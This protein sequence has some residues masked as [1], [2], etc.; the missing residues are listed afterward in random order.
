V[1]PPIV[2]LAHFFC[3]FL[4]PSSL[5]LSG[6]RTRL[7]SCCAAAPVCMC[8]CECVCV[9][10]FDLRYVPG[11]AIKCAG[12][13]VCVHVCVCVCVCV[14]VCMCVCVCACVYVCVRACVC[15][16]VCVSKCEIDRTASVVVCDCVCKIDKTNLNMISA[17]STWC[18][19]SLKLE[20]PTLN[21]HLLPSKLQTSVPLSFE[22]RTHLHPFPTQIKHSSIKHTP[23]LSPHLKKGTPLNP[24]STKM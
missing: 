17:E 7:R 2:I 4:P 15:V 18:Q 20:P 12:L 3:R 6:R 13:C 16:C 11:V 19:C 14:H 9:C 24:P 21:L 23:Y 5:P 10:V 1:A 22:T 8:V